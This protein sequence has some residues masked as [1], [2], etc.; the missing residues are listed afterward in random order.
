MS[1]NG[2]F[3][4]ARVLFFDS[5]EVIRQLPVTPAAADNIATHRPRGR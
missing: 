4:L 5:F 1:V 2:R 3:L